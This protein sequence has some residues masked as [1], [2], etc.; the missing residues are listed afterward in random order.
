MGGG[1]GI[2]RFRTWSRPTPVRGTEAAMSNRFFDELPWYI[3][4]ART[5]GNK[6]GLGRWYKRRLSKARRRW[7]RLFCTIEDDAYRHLGGLI[8][9]ETECNWKGW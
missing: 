8:S 7:A 1:R 9:A 4:F 6:P 5:W 2:G 3:G